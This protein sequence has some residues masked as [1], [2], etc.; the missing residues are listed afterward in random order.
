MFNRVAQQDVVTS[1]NITGIMSRSKKRAPVSTGCCCK[2]QKR[3]KQRSSR[4]FRRFEH[5]MVATENYD[6]LLHRSYEVMEPWSL[7]GDGKFYYKADPHDE[8]YTKLMRK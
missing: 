4:K 2:S 6:R 3:G 7:G 1:H 8:W 5:Q